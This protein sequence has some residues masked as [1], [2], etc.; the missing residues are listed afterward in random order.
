MRILF[1]SKRFLLVFP[2]IFSIL[3]S[4]GSRVLL[5]CFVPDF[6]WT[7]ASLTRAARPA[8][9]A[10][11]K[12]H[13]KCTPI[14]GVGNFLKKL[15]FSMTVPRKTRTTNE[16]IQAFLQAYSKTCNVVAA[17][18]LCGIARRTHYAW[19]KKYPPYAETFKE[20]RRAA[21][22]FLESIAVERATVG[23]TEPV[24]YQ[25]K[26]AAHVRRYSDGLLMMLLRGFKP[27]KYGVQR[28]EISGPQEAPKQ[29]KVEVVI[30]RPD[31]S[32]KPLQ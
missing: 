16:R 4:L 3:H 10:G 29:A 22:D 20:C 32:R 2:H 23:W 26:V 1:R 25:G 31:G 19:L 6:Q 18:R 5:R 24:L 9:R 11:G 17:C 7:I 30:V 15:T 12:M 13:T 27:E 21:G 8:A 28:Q 14:G